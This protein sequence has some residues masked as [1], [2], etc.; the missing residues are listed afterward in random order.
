MSTA[1]IILVSQRVIVDPATGERRD[2]L[3][4][5][6]PA[7]V[8]QAGLIGIPV[9]NSKG[10]LPAIIESLNPLGVLL[11]GGNDLV[12]L[13]GDAPER[14]LAEEALV[15]WALSEGR[16]LL[17]VC[18][19]MQVIQQWFGVGLH[20]VDGHVAGQQTITFESERVEVNSYHRFGTR[21]TKSPLRIC[22]RAD[23]GVV[24]A[25]RAEGGLI[26]GIM[27]HPERMSVARAADLSLFREFF[28]SP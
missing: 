3:D 24:K 4:Q 19:G 17:G 9:P 13:G 28:A 2:A 26:C 11:T 27:W 15:A 22:G 14:D 6:W 12:G 8:Q 25:I 1:P 21:E 20:P 10:A 23:D 18:R 7:F 5:R 16:P